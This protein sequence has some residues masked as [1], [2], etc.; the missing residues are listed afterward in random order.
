MISVF[1]RC[2]DGGDRA[3]IA[4]P[5][6]RNVFGCVDSDRDGRIDGAELTQPAGCFK[7]CLE[8][9][10]PAGHVDS[11]PDDA[12]VTDVLRMWL[13]GG[14]NAPE[15]F[16]DMIGADQDCISGDQGPCEGCE[17]YHEDFDPMAHRETEDEVQMW[18]E[19]G[20]LLDECD[21]FRH[22]CDHNP[23]DEECRDVMHNEYCN[24]VQS[25]EKDHLDRCLDYFQKCCPNAIAGDGD[26]MLEECQPVQDPTSSEWYA[27]NADHEQ[28]GC[29]ILDG[30][31]ESI[32]DHAPELNYPELSYCGGVFER[33]RYDMIEAGKLGNGGKPE[34]I[35]GDVASGF[36]LQ[37]S[38]RQ[39]GKRHSI[40]PAHVASRRML[41]SQQKESRNLHH[42]FRY[43]PYP[44][45]Q[46]S[47][48]AVSKFQKVF[49]DKA[50]AKKA[51]KIN[52]ANVARK[53][54]NGRVLNMIAK[55]ASSTDPADPSL[56]PVG[57]E[58]AANVD[59]VSV[60][61][62]P[63]NAKPE[64]I[65]ARE[66]EREAPGVET[67]NSHVGVAV[68]A[69]PNSD[70]TAYDPTIHEDAISEPRCPVEKFVNAE[71]GEEQIV[72][73]TEYYHMFCAW[74]HEVAKPA[75]GWDLGHFIDQAT[76]NFA[77]KQFEPD[78]TCQPEIKIEDTVARSSREDLHDDN[79]SNCQEAWKKCEASAGAAT[80]CEYLV[81]PACEGFQPMDSTEEIEP[82]LPHVVPH[83]KETPVNNASVPPQ[84]APV[85]SP[86]NG[87]IPAG[88]G[89][90]AQVIPVG[91][92]GEL[93][94]AA[95]AEEQ[96]APAGSSPSLVAEEK[97]NIFPES[98]NSIAEPVKQGT[99]SD[100]ET[101]QAIATL[102]KTQRVH[103]GVSKDG[104][105]HVTFKIEVEED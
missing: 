88:T 25:V 69:S 22:R 43:Q 19:D 3:F 11:V 80:Q 21:A 83:P 8:G 17:S 50:Y 102:L 87:V 96:A 93:P 27:A 24:G 82:K 97:A 53:D 9:K 52:V 10:E 84:T 56:L 74:M 30:K 62:A 31:S 75:Y 67:L 55:K 35:S 70:I 6:I 13:T 89:T 23:D 34:D 39:G 77:N 42:R 66:G 1:E 76:V 49:A 38:K 47:S 48:Q 40:V 61:E 20:D 36:F 64:P 54:M 101:A 41:N 98:A 37:F 2:A 65:S 18:D 71:N 72:R 78:S 73:N 4:L 32:P 99:V 51:R 103:T 95:P 104:K 81:T 14:E 85:P 68:G 86:E 63:I 91:T 26:V 105:H 94:G 90:T 45:G 33:S 29:Y 12:D 15:S 100:D 46:R 5:R 79:K 58:G 44:S 92:G 28:G 57:E 60:S 16:Q 59:P 7:A